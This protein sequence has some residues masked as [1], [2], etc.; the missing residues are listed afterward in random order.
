[1]NWVGDPAVL[2]R[3]PVEASRLK[4]STPPTVPNTLVPVT[5]RNFP[6]GLNV[7]LLASPSRDTTNPARGV[8]AAVVVSRVKP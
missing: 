4:T 2:V 6:V 7:L 3:A 1:M 5:S 8:I